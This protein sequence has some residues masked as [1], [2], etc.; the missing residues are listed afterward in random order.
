MTLSHLLALAQQAVEQAER[1]TPGPWTWEDSPP[2]LYAG[3]TPTLHG[4]NLLGRLEIDWNG[5]NNMDFIASSRTTLPVLARAVL[6]LLPFVRHSFSCEANS[7]GD[8]HCGLDRSLAAI[9]QGEGK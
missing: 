4:L 3:R 9:E 7:G 5:K 1:A 6:E 2:T 8:C